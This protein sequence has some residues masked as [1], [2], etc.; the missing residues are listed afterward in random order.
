MYDDEIHPSEVAEALHYHGEYRP[1]F[2]YTPM[3]GHIGDATGLIYYKGEYHLFY[4]FDPWSLKR[5]EH[6]NWGHAV[7][8]D[9]IH[10]EER[11]PILDTLIDNKPGSG[12][13]IVDWNNSSGYRR[14]IEKTLIVFYTDYVRGTCITY[15]ND[16]G[17]SWLRHKENPVLP[18]ADDVRD[19]YVFWYK[20]ANEWRMIRYEKKG[21]AFYR[22]DSLLEWAYLSRMDGFYECPDVCYLPV[23]GNVDNMKWVLIDGDG[24]YF[25]GNFDG[26][27][28]LPEAEK[29]RVNHGRSS[30]YGVGQF[31]IPYAAQTWKQTF[32]GDGPV[33]QMAFIGYQDEP[34]LTW[35][36]QMSFPCELTLRSYPEGIRLCRNPVNAIKNLYDKQYRWRDLDV[37]SDVNPLD[38]ISGTLFDISADID[39]LEAGAFGFEIRGE[40]IRYDVGEKA[41]SW[42]DTAPL[43]LINKRIKLRILV[44]R[45]SI[46]VFA[47]DGK[48][49]ITNLFFPDPAKNKIALFA[50]GGSIRVASMEVN[51]LESI[52]QKRDLE[53]GYHSLIERGDG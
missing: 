12:S 52:W 28:F 49:S 1:Q 45:S 16:R 7:S 4:M 22:S 37:P 25:V 50:E 44:D 20:P 6:K 19:P 39:P 51:H 26:E 15:S 14:G 29:L 33:T 17:G 46:E 27:R 10:W 35:I 3:Q 24:T 32:E 48:A 43:E 9:L 34:R 41:L 30:Y 23:D 18:G 13:G 53:L 21:F 8:R 11:P 2:H 5:K 38:G 36:G 42:R 40:R 47:N 31:S